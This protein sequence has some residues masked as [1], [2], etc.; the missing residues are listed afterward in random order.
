MAG[1]VLVDAGFLVALLSRRDAHHSWAVT[2]AKRFPPPWQTCEAALSE[3]FHLV[4]GSGTNA[5][6]Q[7]LRRSAIGIP[8][9]L[10]VDLEPVLTLLEKY[11]NV[12]ASVADASLVR[13]TETLAD[14]TL[15]TTDTDFRVYRRHSR[16][17]IPCVLP[18]P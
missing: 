1:S 11:R 16:Q 15:L 17:V 4:G 6:C 18:A 13:M 5:L 14:P 12:P 10:A 3:A 8:F 2:V 9:D 7:L